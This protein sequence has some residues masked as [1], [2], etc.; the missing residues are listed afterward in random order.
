[1]QTYSYYQTTRYYSG[2]VHRVDHDGIAY[3]AAIDLDN[4]HGYDGCGAAVR[5][6]LAHTEHSVP[7]LPTDGACPNGCC[8][9]REYALVARLWNGTV[10]A[11]ARAFERGVVDEE[12]SAQDVARLV[13]RVTRRLG[14][15]VTFISVD[16][17]GNATVDAHPKTGYYG[18][19]GWFIVVDEYEH[20]VWDYARMCAAYM[21]RETWA[22]GTMP[23]EDADKL[24]EDATPFECPDT[25]YGFVW[26][27]VDDCGC[28]TPTEDELIACA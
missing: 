6:P 28:S 20:G 9:K 8:A 17:H 7:L 5:A 23:V 22:V 15:G 14:I 1:M 25:T 24:G 12:M 3:L 13:H 2:D 18:D 11:D 10:E 26:E 27:D 19:E 4:E 16:Y 21:N